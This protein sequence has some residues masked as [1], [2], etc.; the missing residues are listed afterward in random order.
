MVN[1]AMGREGAWCGGM[2]FLE[3][4]VCSL[5]LEIYDNVASV[6]FRK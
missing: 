3:I 2:G 1:I 6:N 5:F 4:H